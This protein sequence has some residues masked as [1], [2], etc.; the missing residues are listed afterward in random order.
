[1]FDEGDTIARPRRLV[2]WTSV[3][4]LMVLPVVVLRAFEGGEWD[5]GDAIFLAI[6]FGG[7]ALAY[8]IAA[9]VPGR[10]AYPAAVGIAV[11]A[12]LLNAWI[13]LAVGIIGSED[14]PANFIYHALIAVAL[15][16]S[17][18]AGFRPLGMAHAMAATAGAQ[19]LAFVAAL[20][21]GLGFTGPITV[22]FTGL[23]LISAGL[24]LRA[25]RYSAPAGAAV[26][27]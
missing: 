3:A 23:W 15:V 18:V 7:V 27:S 13:N 25:A 17:V 8:E 2:F 10:R 6:L 11:A 4:A 19:A 1:M 22:F 5:P 20:A 16:G 24:F 9:R 21:A 12:V 14:N 26:K